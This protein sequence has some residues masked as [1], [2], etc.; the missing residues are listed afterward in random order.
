MKAKHSAVCLL[1][2]FGFAVI[3]SR[4]SLEYSFLYFVSIIYFVAHT[5]MC[6]FQYSQ[7]FDVVIAAY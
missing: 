5:F 3:F 7:Y 4:A 1:S 6:A 2:V